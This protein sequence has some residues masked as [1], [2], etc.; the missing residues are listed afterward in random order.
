MVAYGE[1]RSGSWPT[2]LLPRLPASHLRRVR[3]GTRAEAAAPRG[4]NQ[5]FVD[6]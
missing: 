6:C 5:A 1:R 2:P 3:W 4:W